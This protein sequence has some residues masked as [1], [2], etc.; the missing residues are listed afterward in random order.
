MQKVYIF[1]KKKRQKTTVGNKEFARRA[2]HYEYFSK[3]DKS[4]YEIRISREKKLT[5]ATIKL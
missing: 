4:I 5:T 3:V 1:L 2:Y